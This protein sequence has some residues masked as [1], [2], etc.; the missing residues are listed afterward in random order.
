VEQ[1]GCLCGA[2]QVF[3]EYKLKDYYFCRNGK[4]Q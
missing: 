3:A 4:A 1:K 2:C